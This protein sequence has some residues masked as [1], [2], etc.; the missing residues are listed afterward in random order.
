VKELFG[1]HA[2]KL[3]M[4]S[5]KSCTGHT[6]GAAG[7]LESIAVVKAICDGVMPPT[8]NLDQPD[9]GFDLNFVANEAQEREITIALNNSFGF[10][11]HNVSIAIAAFND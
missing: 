4:S 1:D 5:T 9:E 8:I 10:G 7:G 3:A 11:G 2:Y 6:L